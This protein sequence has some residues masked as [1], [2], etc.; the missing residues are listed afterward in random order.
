MTLYEWY[1]LGHIFGAVV[2][3]GG[4][5]TMSLMAWRIQASGDRLQLAHTTGFVEWIGSR[6]YAPVSLFVI[7]MGVL[8]VIEG[9]WSFGDT[10]ISLAL[11]GFVLSFLI[12]A[13][14][15]GPESGRVKRLADE[16]GADAPEVQARTDRL[17]L[18]ARL[19]LVLLFAIIVLMVWKPGV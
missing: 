1:L 18:V 6:V 4:A 9:P 5:A 7:L 11:G 8:M 10:W 15:L 19:D 16:S 17:L 13:G 14:F 3:V 2:W 12:G